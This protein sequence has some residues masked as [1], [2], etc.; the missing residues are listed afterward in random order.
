LQKGEEHIQ[1]NENCKSYSE[2]YDSHDTIKEAYENLFD[3]EGNYLEKKELNALVGYKKWSSQRDIFSFNEK[4]EFPKIET[5]K[6]GEESEEGEEQTTNVEESEFSPI[7]LEAH[8]SIRFPN[9]R[10]GDGKKNLVLEL[11]Y[12]YRP[13]RVRFE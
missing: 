4:M 13:V 2:S 5:K 3:S 12:L 7:V 9:P 6:E 1:K 8:Y 11:D 10:G